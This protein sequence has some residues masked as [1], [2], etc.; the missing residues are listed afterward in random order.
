MSKEAEAMV[1]RGSVKLTPNV[2]SMMDPDY[3]AMMLAMDTLWASE[4]VQDTSPEAGDGLPST[5]TT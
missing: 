5:D 1:P 2:S 4:D 3:M